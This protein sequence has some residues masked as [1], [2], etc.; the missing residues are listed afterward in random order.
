VGIVR[1]KRK[2]MLPDYF[3]LG[4]GKGEREVRFVTWHMRRGGREGTAGDPDSAGGRG[5]KR[6]HGD[7][8]IVCWTGKKEGDGVA[9]KSAGIFSI[10]GERGGEKKKKEGGARSKRR[11]WCCFGYRPLRATGP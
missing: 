4:V 6:K 9:G 2:E 8:V 10:S 11:G 5:K 7:A 1:G 3:F